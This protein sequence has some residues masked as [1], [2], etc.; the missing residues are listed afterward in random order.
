MSLEAGATFLK[1][2]QESKKVTRIASDMNLNIRR[3]NIHA[4]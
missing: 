4:N 3:V 2:E 1:Q